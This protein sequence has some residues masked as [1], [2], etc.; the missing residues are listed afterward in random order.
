MS[1]ALLILA[2]FIHSVDQSYQI[3]EINT[4]NVAVQFL[5]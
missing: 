1:Q 5:D 3:N 2:Q 4:M